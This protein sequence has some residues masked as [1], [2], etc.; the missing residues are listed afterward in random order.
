M[1]M[2]GFLVFFLILLAGG[3]ALIFSRRPWGEELIRLDKHK[4]KMKVKYHEEEEINIFLTQR[5]NYLAQ[6]LAQAGLEAKYDQMKMRWGVTTIAG[7]FVGA[8][9]AFFTLPE[10]LVIGFIIGLI[11][12]AGGFVAYI[13]FLAKQRQAR[14]MEQLPQVLETMV[15]SLRSGS[16]VIEVWKLLAE[17]GVEPIKSEFKRGLVSLQLGKPFREV[18]AEMSVR[19]PTPDFKLLTTAIFISQDVGGNLAEVVATIAVAIR[20][21][22]KLRDYMN[23]LTAQGKMTAMFI[24]SLPYLVTLLTYLISPGYIVPFLNHPI[25]RLVLLGLVIWEALGA[26]ILLKMTSFEV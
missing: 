15:S 17:T 14:I 18:M 2:I 11:A 16:P 25:A 1:E 24:G 21:R 3:A 9:I 13:G 4:K 19:I 7:G 20:A 26:W 22:F 10:L 8:G 5:T 12:G 23:A 6:K